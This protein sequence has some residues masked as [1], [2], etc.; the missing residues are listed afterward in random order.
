MAT[1]KEIADARAAWAGASDEDIAS[2]F[3]LFGQD[4]QARSEALS[5]ADMVALLERFDPN[6]DYDTLSSGELLELMNHFAQDDDK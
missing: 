5:D 6:G 1:P 3:T 4:P 2:E